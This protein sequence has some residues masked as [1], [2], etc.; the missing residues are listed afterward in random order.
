MVEGKRERAEEASGSPQKSPRLDPLVAPAAGPS[1]EEAEPAT[2]SDSTVDSMD[3]SGRCHHILYDLEIVVQDL[4]VANKVLKGPR[5]CQRRD[6]KTTWKGGGEDD[7]GMTKCIDCALF[8]CSGWPVDR[9][10]P[11]GH[12]RWHAGGHQH[13]V[14]Q[15]CDEP[16]LGY[17]FLCERP[18]RLSDC[19]EDDYAVAA[20]NEKDQQAPGV[21]VAKDGWGTMASIAKDGWETGTH[22]PPAYPTESSEWPSSV[23]AAAGTSSY[24]TGDSGRCQHIGLDLERLDMHVYDLWDQPTVLWGCSLLKCT[25]PWKGNKGIMKCIDCTTF[26]CS[27]WPVD[28]ESPQGHAL[29]H[30]LGSLHWV[31]QWCDVPN[32]GYCFLCARGMRLTDWT[33][34]GYAAP[35][36]NVMDDHASGYACGDGYFIRRIPN[37]GLTCYMNAT[38]QCLLALGKMRTIIQSPDA[39]LGSIGL[40]L[41]QLFLETLIANDARYTLNPLMILEA[42]RERYPNRFVGGKMEDS[43][44]FLISLF[45]AVDTEV[46]EK[47]GE[48]VLQG[49]EV[50][51]TFGVSLF[52]GQ[53][54]ETISCQR[55]RRNDL[56]TV[57]FG[58]LFLSL[59]EKDPPARSVASPPMNKSHKSQTDNS[60]GDNKVQTVAEGSTSQIPGSGLGDGAME[61]TPRPLQVDSSEVKDVV[62]GHMQTQKNDVKQEIIEVPIEILDFIPDLFDDTEGMEEATT[63][64][65]N[66]K[67]KETT[68]SVKVTTK[69]KEEAQSSDIAHDEAEHMNSLGSIE[70]FL[71]LFARGKE[72]CENC[73]KVAE[74]IVGRTNI[75][76]TVD[77]DQTEL[78]DRKTCPSERSSDCNSLSVES[79]SRQPYCSDVH[80]QVLLS[81]NITTEEITPGTSCGE[82]DSASCSIANEKAEIDQGVQEAGLP[83]DKQ[84]DLLN[85][86]DSPDTS[87]QNQGCAKQAMLDDHTAEQMEENQNKQKDGNS[88]AIRTQ[89]INK[90]PAVLIVPFKRYNSDLSKVRGRVSFKEILHLGPFMDP[91]SEDRANFRYRLVGVIEHSGHQMNSGHYIA[92]VRGAGHNHESSGSSS[93]VSASDLDIKEVSLEEVVRGEAYMLFYERMEDTDACP[94]FY[95]TKQSEAG[96]PTKEAEGLD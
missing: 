36:R 84:T 67:D 65:R 14:A 22:S 58:E 48:H 83:A 19:S 30:A 9:E 52:G 5:Q 8:F 18:M 35:A 78:S 61:K 10:S 29:S 40:L 71:K 88:C 39:H 66:P 7:H 63:D 15:W 13:W 59:P 37:F 17:C 4:K 42:M 92:Y 93:W 55:C 25:T 79:P 62:H 44:E 94:A 33:K 73:S 11:K 85:A 12:A 80:H 16:N 46:E 76:T 60:G 51:P 89:L 27:G 2:S 90:L 21:S 49:G 91:R 54:F 77:G 34:D 24:I 43:H 56:R 28:R 57:D 70:D 75:N 32:W 1:S 31:A 23:E 81:E 87:T 38:L 96:A 47:N 45:N 6:C 69:D 26:L 20:R 95:P 53:L 50:F 72:R 68:Y 74:Q 86:Q 41:K 64:S 82:K 3:D